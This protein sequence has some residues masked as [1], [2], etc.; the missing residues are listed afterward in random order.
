MVPGAPD[1]LLT[2]VT[3]ESHGHGTGVGLTLGGAQEARQKVFC[4]RER[5][6]QVCNTGQLLFLLLFICM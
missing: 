1:N 4:L 3:S 5:L 2:L 6:G